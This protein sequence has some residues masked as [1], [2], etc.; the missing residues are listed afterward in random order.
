MPSYPVKY[1]QDGILSSGRNGMLKNQSVKSGVSHSICWPMVHCFNKVERITHCVANSWQHQLSTF[2]SSLVHACS[3]LKLCNPR[4][5]VSSLGLLSLW[6]SS[7]VWTD[8]VCRPTSSGIVEGPQRLWRKQWISIS[9]FLVLPCHPHRQSCN[10]CDW[11]GPAIQ[12]LAHPVGLHLLGR[13]CLDP[14]LGA[15]YAGAPCVSQSWISSASGSPAALANIHSM[16]ALSLVCK[17][18][19]LLCGWSAKA[20][21]SLFA[22]CS[23]CASVGPASSSWLPIAWRH[24]DSS[25]GCYCKCCC[26][27]WYT[28]C[29]ATLYPGNSLLIFFGFLIASQRWS[30]CSSNTV[31]WP[32]KG[33][34]IRTL[35][36]DGNLVFISP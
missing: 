30:T 10:C 9:R 26:R 25:S 23:C 19:W 16:S 14:V 7:Q 35:V 17:P 21:L 12:S 32:R 1:K 6:L 33:A 36:A 3:R 15:R 2:C 18:I 13:C 31:G 4:W 34:V 20:S 5:A 27:T 24:M 11:W 8:E 29:P 28:L 22:T